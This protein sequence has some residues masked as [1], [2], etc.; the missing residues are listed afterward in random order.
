MYRYDCTYIVIYM[1]IYIYVSE[2][3]VIADSNSLIK[4]L[5]R[6]LREN[7]Q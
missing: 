7:L 6:G 3:A 1:Y 4:Y 5:W 2:A